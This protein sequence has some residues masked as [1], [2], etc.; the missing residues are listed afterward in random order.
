VKQ[1]SGAKP[2]DDDRPFGTGSA[3][4]SGT[5]QYSVIS[6]AV[7]QRHTRSPIFHSVTALLFATTSPAIS[8]PG[9]SEASGGTGSCRVR[10][11]HVGAVDARRNDLDQD[12]VRLRLRHGRSVSFKYF[13]AAGLLIS[14]AA[15][16]AREAAWRSAILIHLLQRARL[17]PC[18]RPA[19]VDVSPGKDHADAPP[20]KARAR[21]ASSPEGARG[22]A[23]RS[24]STMIFNPLPQK[25]IARSSSSR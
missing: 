16:S 23:R 15:H 13:G 2:P 9:K 18:G 21:R 24:G 11:Q 1:V 5:V 14:T 8:R 3:C 19:Q 10:L 4:T 17:Q 22:R 25:N 6:A 7:R 20:R 12:L